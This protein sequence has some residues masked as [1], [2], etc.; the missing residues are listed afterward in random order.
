MKDAVRDR[1]GFAFF[2]FIAVIAGLSA[3]KAPSILAWLYAL[4]NLIL[5]GIYTRRERAT[6]YD[7]IG[8]GLGMIA[9]LLPTSINNGPT[10]WYLLIAGLL[11]YGLIIW[12]LLVLGKRFGIA[13]ADRGV[14]NRGP[15]RLVRHPMYLG[16]MIYRAALLLTSNMFATQ[17]ALLFLLI[18][19][20]IWRIVREEQWISDYQCYTTT[21]HW[22][23]VPGIW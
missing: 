21:V 16:E 23:L 2:A 11:G 22:R 10:P 15:Y 4:H 18:V 19:I 8:L 17:L 1:L 9:A 7:R 12:S 3:W 20:Q 5:A 13:P 14:T 6:K